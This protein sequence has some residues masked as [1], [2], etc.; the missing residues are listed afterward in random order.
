MPRPQHTHSLD[1]LEEAVSMLF[2]LV[3]EQVS[4]ACLLEYL[5][6]RRVSTANTAAESV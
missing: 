4:P 3:E 1:H 5:W 2:Y 6:V